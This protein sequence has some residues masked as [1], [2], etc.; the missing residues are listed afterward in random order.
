[1]HQSIKEIIVLRAQN[2]LL[3]TS[4]QESLAASPLHAAVELSIHAECKS[5]PNLRPVVK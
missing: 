3:Q 1:M 4:F 2:E 5:S